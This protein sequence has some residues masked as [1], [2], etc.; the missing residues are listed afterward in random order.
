MILGVQ[1]KNQA[2]VVISVINTGDNLSQIQPNKICTRSHDRASYVFP[3]MS[4]PWNLSKTLI[5]DIVSKISMNNKYHISILYI[6][7]WCRCIELGVSC[8]P[9]LIKTKI[10]LCAFP[11]NTRSGTRA[12]SQVFVQSN[13]H[14]RPLDFSP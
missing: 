2:I 5:T 10:E 7:F 14:Y 8:L 11:P 6:S 13:S 12:T 3:E 9:E 1:L 4:E